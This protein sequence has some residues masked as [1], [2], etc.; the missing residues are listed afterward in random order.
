MELFKITHSVPV[1]LGPDSDV[2]PESKTIGSRCHH[3][4]VFALSKKEACGRERVTL[5]LVGGPGV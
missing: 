1:A 5:F 4:L 2:Q 3:F